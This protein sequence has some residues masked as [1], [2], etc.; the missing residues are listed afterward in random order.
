MP[1]LLAAATTTLEAGLYDYLTRQSDYTGHAA[2]PFVQPLTLDGTRLSHR[3]DARRELRSRVG[4]RVY[5]DR[6]PEDAGDQ[7]S[8]VLRYMNGS[9]EYGLAGEAPCSEAFL[10]LTVYTS[11]ADAARRGGTIYGLVHTALS[12]YHAGYWGDV[13]IGECLVD[14]ARTLATPPPDASDRWT[15]T[16]R[17]NIS[18][19]YYAAN[20]P[21]YS[22]YP[23]SA[24]LLGTVTSSDLRLDSTSSLIAQGISLTTV[25]WQLRLTPG[26]TP[27]VSISGAPGAVPS[28]SG[29]TGTF[30]APSV[31]FATYPTLA[32]TNVYTTLTLTDASGETSTSTTTFAT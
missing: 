10:E 19:Y 18:V 6:R 30:A 8:I 13:L 9:H 20:T 1:Q 15:F 3:N 16:R 31:S 12:G 22:E 23:L 32:G 27:V 17:M 26:G 2:R 25:A 14:A 4:N 29:V 28:T 11:G 21:T 7:P 24:V 5:L